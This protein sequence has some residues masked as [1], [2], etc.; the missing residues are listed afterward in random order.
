MLLR[1]VRFLAAARRSGLVDERA[2]GKLAEHLRP[3][4]TV[5]DV[6]GRADLDAAV[7]RAATLALLWRGGWVTDLRRP[8]SPHSVLVAG[9]RAA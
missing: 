7:A 8:L 3:G 9:T 4:M 5:A 6:E 2:I 1:N